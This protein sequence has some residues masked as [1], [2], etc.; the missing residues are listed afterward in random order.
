MADTF[1]TNY[2]WVLPEVGAS[3]DTWGTKLN[4]DL[5]AIDALLKP[6]GDP[7]N[8]GKFAILTGQNTFTGQQRFPVEGM[9]NLGSYYMAGNNYRMYK[10]A[11][12]YIVFDTDAGPAARLDDGGGLGNSLSI[13]TRGTGDA[14]YVASAG[15]G[16]VKP[17]RQIATGSGLSGGGD[18]SANRTLSVDATVVRTTGAQEI[19]GAKTVKSYWSWDTQAAGIQMDSPAGDT[20]CIY[21]RRAGLTY[22]IMTHLA[23][24]E[25]AFKAFNGANYRVENPMAFFTGSNTINLERHASDGAGAS[26]CFRPNSNPASGLLF[27]VRGSGGGLTLGASLSRIAT[28]QS[29]IYVNTDDAGAGGDP[30]VHAGLAQSAVGQFAWASRFQGTS[31]LYGGTTSGANL[32]PAQD[33]ADQNITLP[34]TW[35]CLGTASTSGGTLWQRIA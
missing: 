27:S 15:T 26:I 10:G 1:T 20:N 32:H 25:V 19:S 4:D 11:G 34:G 17:E 33:G 29:G 24:N 2:N 8:G 9:V 21:F 16:Y 28:A 18:L 14:R 22:G 6:N 13:V 7:S 31:V 23:S 30:V 3:R 35:R 12:A 5:R